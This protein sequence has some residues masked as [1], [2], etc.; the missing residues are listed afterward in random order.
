MLRLHAGP[1]FKETVLRVRRD[2]VRLPPSRSK[3]DVAHGSGKADGL[4]PGY[5]GRNMETGGI[6]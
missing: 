3:V 5:M 6:S 2:S 4:T 1:G